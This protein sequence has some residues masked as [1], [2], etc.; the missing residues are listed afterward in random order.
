MNDNDVVIALSNLMHDNCWKI[1]AHAIRGKLTII[2]LLCYTFLTIALGL[3]KANNSD[4]ISHLLWAIRFE[5][6]P[7]VRAEACHTLS[8]LGLRNDKVAQT[9]RD[10]LIVEDNRLVLKYL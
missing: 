6:L 3:L 7:Q 2:T 10:I 9:F 4:I 1:K 8:L 5:R